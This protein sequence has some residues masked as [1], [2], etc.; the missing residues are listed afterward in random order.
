M[1]PWISNGAK[2]NNYLPQMFEIKLKNASDM[3]QFRKIISPKDYKNIL[4]LTVDNKN[5][6]KIS[7]I[8]NANHYIKY[9]V[10]LILFFISNSLINIWESFMRA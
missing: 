8:H 2:L 4:L 6:I 10:V 7:T 3:D 5:K 9:N 1:Q